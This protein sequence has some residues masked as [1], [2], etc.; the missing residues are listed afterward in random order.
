ME[1]RHLRYFI[2]VAEEL[3]FRRAAERL[4]MAQPPLSQQIRQFEGE[5]GTR[6]I[7]RGRPARLTAAGEAVLSEARK[8]LQQAERIREAAQ[9]AA[10]GERGR[11]RLGLCNSAPYGPLPALLRRFRAAAPEVELAII[12][13]SSEEQRTMLLAGQLDLG[14]LRLPLA[15]PLDGLRYATVCREELIVALPSDHP[16]CRRRTVPLRAL[17]GESFISFPPSASPSLFGQIEAACRGAGFAP[18]IAQEALQMQTIVSLVATG[19]GVALLPASLR[20]L[21]RSG[22]EYRPL[23][24]STPQ[25]E[26]VLAW[27]HD[28]ASALVQRFVDLI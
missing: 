23:G 15:Q 17:R 6:L 2:A 19:L 5:L 7:E 26:I 25:T 21:R 1:L 8:T 20:E 12:E 3:N 9:Q 18:R 14:A 13:R 24:G 22:V 28:R 4:R 10:R 16:L 27:P 11:L